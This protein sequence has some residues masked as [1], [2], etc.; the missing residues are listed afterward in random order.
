LLATRSLDNSGLR[1]CAPRA[2][3]DHHPRAILSFG[4][5]RD[6]ICSDETAKLIL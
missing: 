2:F 4:R 5:R 3:S 1:R 6:I